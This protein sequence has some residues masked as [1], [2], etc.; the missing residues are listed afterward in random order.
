[1][2]LEEEEVLLMVTALNSLNRGDTHHLFIYT[3]KLATLIT[4]LLV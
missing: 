2:E 1:M 4:I 3:H